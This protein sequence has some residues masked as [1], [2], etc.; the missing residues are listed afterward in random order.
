VNPTDED[1]AT[2]AA[3]DPD[4]YYFFN[5]DLAIQNQLRFAV[6]EI[7]NQEL[8]NNEEFVDRDV[9]YMANPKNHG[10]A[11][12]KFD[13]NA[14]YTSGDKN[15]EYKTMAKNSLYIVGKKNVSG[16]PELEIVFV[17]EVDDANLTG[18]ENVKTAE[19]NND[20]IYNL[21]GVRVN[22]AQKGIF[23]MNGKKFVVK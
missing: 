20:A 19:Q 7:A 1:L 17:D 4:E 18:I 6:A 22:K 12:T 15:G 5:K 21:Q 14:K 13:K 16:A 2:F 23:I 3:G 11:F 9:Y 10:F 8:K